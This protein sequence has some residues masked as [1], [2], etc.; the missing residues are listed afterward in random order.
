M[1]TCFKNFTGV[2]ELKFQVRPLKHLAVEV[3]KIADFNELRPY[4]LELQA[5]PAAFQKEISKLSAH[6]KN[7]TEEQ[8][9]DR[10]QL[11]SA[12]YFSS[13][14]CKQIPP[15]LIEAAQVH[16]ED[17]EPAVLRIFGQKLF[18]LNQWPLA[19]KIIQ[20]KFKA[21]SGT[22]PSLEETLKFEIYALNGNFQ[23]MIEQLPHMA[24]S[25]IPQEIYYLLLNLMNFK[26]GTEVASILKANP[27]FDYD[28]WRRIVQIA[29]KGKLASK[30]P[31]SFEAFLR[32]T[33]ALSSRIRIEPSLLT[34]ALS[35][36]SGIDE[37]VK[38]NS[39]QIKQL[40]S[41]F[42]SISK[43]KLMILASNLKS[44]DKKM[45]QDIS[46]ILLRELCR[47]YKTTDVDV[48]LSSFLCWMVKYY[49]ENYS[50]DQLM[51]EF[52]PAI[53]ENVA[54][55]S[56]ELMG[57]KDPNAT[58]FI[59]FCM[60]EKQISM[61]KITL[62]TAVDIAT[63]NFGYEP[64]EAFMKFIHGNGYNL[65]SRFYLNHLKKTMATDVNLNRAFE[66]FKLI[67]AESLHGQLLQD[68][69]R[70]SQSLLE[71]MME[72]SNLD[73]CHKIH[74][75]TSKYQILESLD[76]PKS[77]HEFILTNYK[78]GKFRRPFKATINLECIKVALDAVQQHSSSS[79]HIL[80]E[81]FCVIALQTALINF[82]FT[83]AHRLRVYMNNHGYSTA[84]ISFGQNILKQWLRKLE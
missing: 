28:D 35:K 57:L 53:D 30:K 34:F 80:D 58:K 24:K 84:D 42:R 62:K 47:N 52:S 41:I 7:L 5:K 39:E 12:L 40:K 17:I 1:I 21:A 19:E 11:N 64:S 81:K 22:L 69:L 71:L 68:Y 14:F 59:E 56:L 73:Q 43:D 49:P 9:S 83:T 33:E 25:E 3:E 8:L 4:F 13:I 78:S 6:Y 67:S 38:I 36:C 37:S 55:I 63:E 82:D 26:D 45:P 74:N 76:R 72:N 75:A 60:M 66:C 44:F 51:S 65:S 10:S 15:K 70:L 31:C 46:L 48:V 2:L 20:R 27:S 50:Y 16:S 29:M 32:Q 77:F 18:R 61:D 54:K 23:K 79:E